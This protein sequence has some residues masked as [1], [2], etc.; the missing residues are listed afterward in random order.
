MKKRIILL[1]GMLISLLVL[2]GC[3]GKEKVAGSQL[4][5][6]ETEVNKGKNLEDEEINVEKEEVQVDAPKRTVAGTV[7]VLDML[8]YLEIEMVAIP[9]TS[10][11]LDDKFKG[12]PNIGKPMKPDMELLKFVDPDMYIS[13]TSLEGDLKDQIEGSNISTVF[14]D[15]SS[16]TTMLES[17]KILGSMYGKED[18]S[19][20]YIKDIEDKSKE[21]K[22]STREGE[23]PRVLI[24]FGSPRSI[25]LA[26]KNS[27]IGSL[28]TELGAINVV[29]E[30]DDFKDNYVPISMENVLGLK[31]DIILRLT[32][33]SPEESRKMF[34][35]EFE[36]S[37]IWKKLDAVKDKKVYDLDNKY[38]GVSG[39]IRI[40]EAFQ[41]LEKMLYE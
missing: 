23:Q 17:M 1:I 35:E 25:M 21:I 31:P 10:Y 30:L 38:F 9:D 37:D 13:V 5:G 27:F 3:N 22:E 26:T 18:I 36:K 39:N 19:N 40:L 2:G 15:N 6:G 41:S 12:V 11:E 24:L 14:L 34:D 20:K 7:A 4:S 8:D 32:H 16:Y 33:A 28:I 29:D